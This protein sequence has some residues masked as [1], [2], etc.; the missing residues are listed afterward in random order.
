MD[1]SP[2]IPGIRQRQKEEAQLLR[3]LTALLAFG[4]R[5]LLSLLATSYPHPGRLTGLVTTEEEGLEHVRRQ[6]PDLLIC[7]DE[8][9]AGDGVA[10]IRRAKALHP[11]LRAVL[12]MQRPTCRTL[13]AAVKAGTEG[14]CTDRLLATGAFHGA[15]QAVLNDGSYLDRD[16]AAVLQRCRLEAGPPLAEPL[17]PRELEVLTL[18]S[19]GC[20]NPVI[21]DALIVS[22]DTVKSHVSSVLAKLNARDRTH[23]AVLAL[24]HGVVKA[25]PNPPA[26]V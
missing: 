25:P 7:S 17:S 22:V 21:A 13:L 23:A 5:A 3:N 19:R 4:Q 11:P 15:L 9:E 16:A 2:L 26:W 14:V 12:I 18:L 8:L 24:Q 10:L 6:P 20:S 1:L